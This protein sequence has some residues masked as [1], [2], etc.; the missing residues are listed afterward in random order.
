MRHPFRKLLA[1]RRKEP[2]L[3]EIRYAAEKPDIGRL[4]QDQDEPHHLDAQDILPETAPPKLFGYYSRSGIEYALREMDIFRR[5]EE[6]GYRNLRAELFGDPWHQTLRLF[7]T[8]AGAEHMVMEGR[9]ISS[10]WLVPDDTPLKAETGDQ[11]YN[12][13]TIEWI[14]LQHPRSEFTPDRARLPGQEHP[15]LGMRDEMNEVF[16]AVARRLHI[17]AYLAYANHFHNAYIYSPVFFFVSPRRQAELNAI[18][19]AGQGRSIQEKSLAI[20]GGCLLD[21]AGRPYEWSGAPMIRP[22]SRDLLSALDR[23]RYRD[24]VERLVEGMS[25]RFDWDRFDAA[26]EEIAAGIFGNDP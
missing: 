9:F 21:H 1:R 8:A 5:I 22:L 18:Q 26:R 10:S 16:F 19:Q 7:G 11:P 3:S 6:K 17:D 12:T 24:H 14:L 2:D 25:F 13:I 15:G 23:C 4:I 20:E